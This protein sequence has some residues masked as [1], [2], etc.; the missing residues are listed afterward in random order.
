MKTNKHKET[1]EFLDAEKLEHIF[2]NLWPSIARTVTTMLYDEVRIRVANA[3]GPLED[4]IEKLTKRN[5]VLNRKLGF[6]D[7][8]IEKMTEVEESLPPSMELFVNTIKKH[9][10]RDRCSITGRDNN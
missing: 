9:G 5:E 4:E 3:L 10:G 1:P 6:F 7:A 8:I 2:T